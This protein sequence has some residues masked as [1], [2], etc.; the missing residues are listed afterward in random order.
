MNPE[1][2]KIIKEINSLEKK[3]FS[4]DSLKK[5]DKQRIQRLLEHKSNRHEELQNFLNE[6]ND[7]FKE[8][9]EIEKEIELI[10]KRTAD[11]NSQLNQVFEEDITKKLNENLKKLE[12]DLSQ[13]EDRGLA[14]LERQETLKSEIY[15]AQN[16]LKG[17]DETIDE[18]KTEIMQE[19]AHKDVSYENIQDRINSLISELD[20]GFKEKYLKLKNKAP[21]LDQLSIIN[22]ERCAFC[23]FKINSSDAQ[24][25]LNLEKLL[26][27]S[28][29]NRILIPGHSAY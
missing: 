19:Q 4:L 3:I 26:G 8:A 21:A 27:C 29:C 13:K 23:G 6:E 24:R 2:F 15:D 20:E 11:L 10:D 17:I 12:Q 7:L 28:M 5:Q 9:I 16:F 25:V 1:Y 14:I 22:D 18:I